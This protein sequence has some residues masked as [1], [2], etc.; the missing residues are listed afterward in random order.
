MVADVQNI[1]AFGTQEFREYVARAYDK[2]R[3]YWCLK[4]KIYTRDESNI[5]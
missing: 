4:I 2:Y 5:D 3:I 1:L